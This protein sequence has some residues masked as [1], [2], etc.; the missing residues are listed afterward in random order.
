MSEFQIKMEIKSPTLLGSGEGLGSIIDTDIVYDNYGLPY[1]PARR[2]KGLLRES[3]IE[4][5]EMFILS[6]IRQLSSINVDFVF[7]R[8]G[9][10]KGAPVSFRNLHLENYDKAVNWL[11]WA[12]KNLDNVISRD[13][14]LDRFTEIRQRTAINKEGT[15]EESSLRTIRVLKA[16]YIFQGNIHL[17]EDDQNILSLLAFAC[18]NLRHVGS[19]RTRGLGEVSCSLWQNQKNLTQSEIENLKEEVCRV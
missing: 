19:N 11:E 15:A 7:G 2:L 10:I 8:R 16:G 4:V 14:V 13:T 3:A 12:F 1:I 17:E 9:S 5:Q 6:G 18:A